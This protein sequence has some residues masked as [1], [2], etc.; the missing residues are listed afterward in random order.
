MVCELYL[1]KLLRGVAMGI[2]LVTTSAG[3]LTSQQNQV[4]LS[5]Q[6]TACVHEMTSSCRDMLDNSW[7]K[8]HDKL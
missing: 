5:M 1:I 8:C 2:S 6:D 3:F 7:N 4:S